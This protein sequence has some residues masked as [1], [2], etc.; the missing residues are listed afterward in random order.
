MYYFKKKP[1]VI[2]ADIAQFLDQEAKEEDEDGDAESF[3]RGEDV[4]KKSS[5]KD[6]Q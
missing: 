5:S 2:S 3:N 1:K 6:D 4:G